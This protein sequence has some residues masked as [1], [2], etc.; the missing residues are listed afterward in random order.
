M[1]CPGQREILNFQKNFARLPAV[2]QV[3]GFDLA[4][5]HQMSDLSGL[6][7]PPS[8]CLDPAPV[9]EHGDAVGQAENLVHLVGDI[10][11]GYST[12]T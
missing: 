1:A 7:L 12:R 11:N 4:S 3:D 6:G 10:E 9:P 5:D 8:K 2:F